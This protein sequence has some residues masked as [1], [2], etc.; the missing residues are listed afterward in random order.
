MK[1][2]LIDAR[3]QAARMSVLAEQAA[4]G[5]GIG[6]LGEKTLHRMLKLTVEEDVAHHEQPLGGHIV[7]VLTDT[8]CVE[9]QT[10]SLGRLK[11]KIP[12]YLAL[13]RRVLILH[14]IPY[15]KHVAW[16]DPHTGDVGERRR[17]PKRGRVYD[18]LFELGTLQQLLLREGVTVALVFMNMDEYRFLDGYDRTRK[19]GS[20]RAERLATRLVSC[21][22]LDS[23]SAYRE[24][25]VPEELPRPF[26]V[27]EYARLTRVKPRWAYTAIRLL[28]SLGVLAHTDT[29][30]REFLYDLADGTGAAR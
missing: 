18:A 15:E 5:G 19:R 9:I 25:L 1:D 3:F 20:H 10:R 14:P 22:W 17:S 2:R 6:T 27:K 26:T 29:R 13:G 16:I 23:P 8:V 24:A 7:D 21:V 11:Q 4:L 12:D 30:G 28:M